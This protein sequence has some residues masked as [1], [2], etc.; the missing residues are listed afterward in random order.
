MAIWKS[1]VFYF[2][3]V[4]L[5]ALAGALIA[6][7]VIDW[8]SYKQNLEIYGERLTGR[9]V[10]INGPVAVRLFPF[11][12]LQADQVVIANSDAADSGTFAEAERVTVRIA[13]DGLFAGELRVQDITVERPVFNFARDTGNVANWILIPQVGLRNSGLLEQVRLDHINVVDGVVRYTEASRPVA[14]QIDALNGTF[15]APSVEGPWRSSGT[16]QLRGNDA[17]FTISTSERVNGEPLRFGLKVTPA[18]T[19]LPSIAFDG[20]SD[21]L[22]TKGKLRIDSVIDESVKGD[23]DAAIRPLSMQGD[24]VATG[25]TADITGIKITPADSADSSLL[26]E[27]DVKFRLTDHLSA[28]ANFKS[29][30]L[31]LDSLLGKQAATNWQA[32]GVLSALHR[33]M[34]FLPDGLDFKSKFTVAALTIKNE[35]LENVEVAAETESNAI[36]LRRLSAILPG[37]TRILADGIV[38]PSGMSAD[39][40]GKIALETNDLRLLSA[41]LWPQPM[42]HIGRWW[43][44]SRGQLKLQS[45]LNWSE[46][47]LGLTEAAFELDGSRGKGAFKVLF[48]EA[49][50]I[51]LGMH[52]GMFNIDD[53]LPKGIALSRENPDTLS[54][55]DVIAAMTPT[56]RSAATRLTIEADSVLLNGVT[57]QNVSLDSSSSPNALDISS[58]AIGSISGAQATAKG[59][60]ALINGAYEGTLRGGVVADDPL[61]VLRLLGVGSAGQKSWQQVLGR[62]TLSATMVF[63]RGIDEPQVSYA[64]EGQSGPLNV[65]IT[66]KLSN[67]TAPEG[68]VLKGVATIGSADSGNILRLFGIEPQTAEAT[69]GKLVVGFDGRAATGYKID[70]EM[71]GYAAK[72]IFDG[73]WQFSSAALPALDG[74]ISLAAENAAPVLQ[75][76]GVPAFPSLIGPLRFAAA[77]KPGVDALRVSAIKGDIAGQTFAGEVSVLPDFSINADLSGGVADMA[78]LLAAGLMPW[79]GEQSAMDHNFADSAPFA[80]NGEVWYRPD[81]L[82]V[83]DHYPVKEGVVGFKFEGRERQVTIAGRNSEGQQLALEAAVLPASNQ[84]TMAMTGKVPFDLQFKASGTGLTPLATMS[85]LSGEG[86]VVVSDSDVMEFAPDRFATLVAGVKSADDLRGAIA[87]LQRDTEVQIGKRSF[88]FSIATGR[89]SLAPFQLDQKSASLDIT[90]EADL[91]EQTV[92]STIRVKIKSP[93]GLP[94]VDLQIAGPPTKLRKRFETSALAGK[95]GYDIMAREMAELERVQAEQQRALEQEEVQRQLDEERFKAYQEQRAELRLRQRELKVFAFQR[96]RDASTLK[97]NVLTRLDEFAAMNKADVIRRIRENR[98]MKATAGGKASKPVKSKRV[99]APK[100][101]DLPQ[102]FE[103]PV[104]ELPIVPAQ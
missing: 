90:G 34:G 64:V 1:P 18:N 104:P 52:I 51:D 5:L 70:A 4:L 2:G 23:F 82:F 16:A 59:R 42:Q 68:A 13:L 96:E 47:Q 86:I 81:T 93:V 30:R 102:F 41:W 60:L 19:I 72:M 58:F 39:F 45:Q 69:D 71:A 84:Y 99:E 75:A 22:E 101:E 26:V 87:A 35:T 17:S 78:T 94:T 9:L 73:T 76:I 49:P 6:P 85:D 66:T 20:T 15:S 53:H 8:N 95:L 7:F 36:R 10:Q 65:A 40:G 91:V 33:I 83:L 32:A 98:I 31:N 63:T 38:F 79:D 25:E 14:I 24:V 62:T 37:K 50:E 80:L 57:A 89:A 28:D 12:R 92:A 3:I 48:G 100:L 103:L 27:G 67:I 29:P 54:W 43:K 21:S 11:P 77:L 44:G 88:P 46:K 74:T 97:N 61:P 56:G 55:P